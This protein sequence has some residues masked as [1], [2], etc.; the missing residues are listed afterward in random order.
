MATYPYALGSDYASLTDLETLL[1]SEGYPRGTVPRGRLYEASVFNDRADGQVAAH[2]FPYCIWVFDVLTIPMI[3]TL[4]TFCPGQSA[5]VYLKTRN[6]ADA[7]VTFSGIMV[8]PTPQQMDKRQVGGKYLGLE[9]TFRQ[10]QEVTVQ[11]DFAN[12]QN[13]GYIALF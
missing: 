5:S 8:W 4:R 12:Y 9:F 3:A 2:G 10:L 11:L 7:F 13:S 1:A 6:Q